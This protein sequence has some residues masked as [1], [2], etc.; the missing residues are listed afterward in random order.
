MSD[1]YIPA[2][3]SLRYVARANVQN[4]CLHHHVFDLPLI[5]DLF[6]CFE[7]ETVVSTTAKAS[8]LMSIKAEGS[9]MKVCERLK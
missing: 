1:G 6:A 3:R 8:H 5:R 7:L 9:R 4:R 2:S